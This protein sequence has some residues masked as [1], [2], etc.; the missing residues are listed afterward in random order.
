MSVYFRIDINIAAMIL[1]GAV[2]IIAYHRL[3]R[4]DSLNQRFL[5]VSLV[6]CIEILIETLTCMING[7][8]G[9]WLQILSGTLHTILFITAPILTCSWCFFIRRW[10]LEDHV[11]SKQ[12]KIFFF[13][14]V[15]MNSIIT[16]LSP[17]L[18]WVF[19]ISSTNVYIRGPLFVLSFV[20]TYFYLLYSIVFIILQRDQI[21]RHE[22]LPIL[23]VS[24][25]PIIGG[26]CQGLFYG[27]LLMW[28]S[29]AFS[30]VIVY[31]FLQQRMIHLDY[32][33]GAWTRESLNY[34]LS[35][36]IKKGIDAAFGA[37][38]LDI[39][40]LK[41]I[42][43]RYGH[44]EGDHAI[45]TT[46]ELIKSILRKADIIARVGGDEFIIVL[47]C[48]SVDTLEQLI[49]RIKAKL[50]AY[51]KKADK[52]YHLECSFGADIF[53]PKDISIEQFIHK[54]DA[55]MYNDKK[56]KLVRSEAFGI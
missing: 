23:A 51:N 20:I 2:F 35:K 19:F 18:G 39:D 47:N 52:Q 33:T 45:K 43:D 42:N 7:E 17:F 6:I 4:K 3:D 29:T 5:A 55:L 9:K 56:K 16:L 13:A 26:I 40:G 32:L 36:K 14:P 12:R 27:V 11:I 10:I 41:Q 50:T 54:I 25:L 38:Y 44:L 30:L 34:F 31:I 48:Q 46:I 53:S 22:F 1:L 24:I 21:M 28:S 49:E 37:I 8:P 15:I